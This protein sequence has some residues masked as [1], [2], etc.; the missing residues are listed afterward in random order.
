[1]AGAAD[2]G[3]RAFERRCDCGAVVVKS[4]AAAEADADCLVD[5]AEDAIE[6]TPRLLQRGDLR[7]L[8]KAEEVH[9]EMGTTAE[10]C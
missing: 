2:D 1:M 8:V 9:P 5:R 4:G 7:I 10:G 3:T 6:L